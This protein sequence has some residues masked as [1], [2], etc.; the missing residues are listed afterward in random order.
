M[1]KL[2]KCWVL[3][4]MVWVGVLGGWGFAGAGEEMVLPQAVPKEIDVSQVPVA[5]EG[6]LEV[7]L[8]ADRGTPRYR[9]GDKVTFLVE[10]TRNCFL[11]LLNVGT[12]GQVK[13][14]FPNAFQKANAVR[15]NIL[16]PIPGQGATYE[17][18]LAGPQG[19]EGVIAICSLDSPSVRPVFPR[20]PG[21]PAP[22]G[23]GRPEPTAKDI[24]VD[25]KPVSQDRWAMAIMTLEVEPAAGKGPR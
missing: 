6:P 16:H 21:Q 2:G 15:A 8:R 20:I 9:A 13:V 4:W 23:D 17:F 7:K 22:L 24:A 3:V 10:A 1:E 25:P 18:T 14:L 12:S 19:L 5:G 11:T